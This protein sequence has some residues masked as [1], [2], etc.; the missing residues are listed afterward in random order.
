MF[1]FLSYLKNVCPMD[2]SNGIKMYH[3]PLLPGYD[4]HVNVRSSTA[5]KMPFL[6]RLSDAEENGYQ[7][8]YF[9]QDSSEANREYTTVD[10]FIPSSSPQTALLQSDTP[11]VEPQTV[12]NKRQEQSGPKEV[13]AK[14][15]GGG[16]GDTVHIEE[17]VAEVVFFAYG[18]VV[19][20]GFTQDQEKM[21]IDDLDNALVL[22]RKIGEDKWEKEE[23]HFSVCFL[24]LYLH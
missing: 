22:V 16:G 18:V 3:L 9:T 2:S 10:G 21:I 20:F 7:G 5:I 6:K 17:N 12:E 24:I 4:P 11:H 23:C 14:P 8:P 19:F 13:E 1:L 15:R